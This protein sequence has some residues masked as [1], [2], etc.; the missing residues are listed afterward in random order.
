M[1]ED[2][3]KPFDDVLSNRHISLQN[4]PRDVGHENAGSLA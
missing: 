2:V 3:L 4:K 1:N